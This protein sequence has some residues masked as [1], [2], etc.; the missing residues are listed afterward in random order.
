VG[1]EGEILYYRREKIII[2]YAWGLR[3]VS[4]NQGEAYT[5]LCGIL[6]AKEANIKALSIIGDSM[7]VIK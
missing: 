3:Q 2:S 5:L 4:N 1:G 7:V 6:L